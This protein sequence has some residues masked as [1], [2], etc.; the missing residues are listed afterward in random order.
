MKYMCYGSTLIQ[1]SCI[2]HDEVIRMS[3]HFRKVLRQKSPLHFPL[4]LA[5]RLISKKVLI[6]ELEQARA[7]VSTRSALK[8]WNLIL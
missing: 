6:L 4:F 7:Q 2:L 1:R 3:H 5:C 8:L